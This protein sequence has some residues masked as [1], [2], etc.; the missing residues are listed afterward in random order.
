MAETAEQIQSRMLTN[1]DD[2]YDK[3]QGSFVY[4]FTKPVAIE[5]ETAYQEQDEILDNGFAETTT[6]TY[7]ERKVAEQGLTRKPATK[8]TTTVT[9]T[10]LEGSVIN[11]GDKVASDNVDFVFTESKTIDV[12]GT[13]DV[14]VECEEAGEIGNVPIG[15]IKYFP[16]TLAELETVTNL[17]IVNNGYA[18]ETDEELRQRYF[19]KVRT[20]STSGNKYH[21]KNWAK[22]VVGV[23]DA[24]VYPLWNGNGTVKVVIIDSNK[25]GAE[26]QLVTDT[27]NHIEDNRPI[28][29]TVTVE[30][31]TEKAINIS[32]TAVKDLNYTDQQ[33]QT[34]IENAVKDY[35]KSIAFI[36]NT[37]SYG[38]I[39][40]AIINSAGILDYSGL[41]VNG[42]T[43]NIALSDSNSLTEVAVLG[44]VTIA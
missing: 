35:L 6:G 40:S 12:S 18:G 20:P 13:V 42:G 38:K 39:G 23:G 37:V 36:E 34:N 31:A 44:V 19:E 26:A 24:K 1:V 5:L 41:T 29:A 32:F 25:T 11:I 33:R 17:N 16:V 3:T 10:G 14:L 28:G 22:E 27:F 43:S 15:A 30:S 21:Y 9:V 2:S 4:D 8:A 7:L